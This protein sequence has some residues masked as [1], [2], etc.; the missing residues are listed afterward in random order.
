MAAD[1]ALPVAPPPQA[2]DAAP[3][4]AECATG[5]LR[6][7]PRT[8]HAAEVKRLS[9]VSN[10]RSA[11]LIGLNW[12]VIVGAVVWS[13]WMPY[14]WVYVIAGVAIASRQQSMGILMH[15]GVHWLLFTNRTVNDVVCDLLVSFPI[16]MSTTLYRK[17]HFQHHRHTNTE[18]D[19]DLAA[20]R[21]EGE[22]YEWPKTPGRFVW[23]LLRTALG[24]NFTRGWIMYK[25]WAPWY[26]LFDPVTPAFPVRA[27]VL[28][29]ASVTAVYSLFGWGFA[30]HPWATLKVALLF[31]VPGLT[32]LNFVNRL[33]AT[34]E[35]VGATG[36]EELTA[37]RTVLPR[38]WERLLIA[39]V[40][41]NYHL[42]HHLFP[43]V[44]GPRLPELHR[45]LMRD[46]AFRARAHLT[47][48][49]TG[50]LRE[51]M[52]KQQPA[53]EETLPGSEQ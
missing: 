8:P 2:A 50:V 17:T 14:W 23:T 25:H 15:D 48:G 45:Y 10:L 22:W 19:C 43:S 40:N 36:D 16:G 11:W 13:F 12:A 5:A 52:A 18:Q 20:M 27:R 32:L 53:R 9:H 26:H 1:T 46:E 47:R 49:Y 37:T 28:Y 21:E 29:V 7:F 4:A 31:M 39:P 41:V 51:L 35:H 3:E 30:N 33:R 38:W 34:A 42:E 6:R 24:V 44:P